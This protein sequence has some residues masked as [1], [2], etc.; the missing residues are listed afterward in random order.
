VFVKVDLFDFKMLPEPPILVPGKPKRKTR[1]LEAVNKFL[2]G[3]RAPIVS[4]CG[5]VAAVGVAVSYPIMSACAMCIPMFARMHKLSFANFSKNLLTGK[6]IVET[7]EEEEDEDEVDEEEIELFES[8]SA[9]RVTEIL[10]NSANVGG[11]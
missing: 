3:P 9:R 7:E 5:C 6:Y 2:C 1:D 11:D 8:E 10:R 4:F